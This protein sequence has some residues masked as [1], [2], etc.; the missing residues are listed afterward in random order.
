MKQLTIDLYSY[1]ELNKSAKEKA[2][3]SLADFLEERVVEDITEEIKYKLSEKGY[4]TEN[5]RWDID[6]NYILFEGKIE[7]SS[8]LRET[9]NTDMPSER[10]QE[11]LNLGKFNIYVTTF[12]CGNI[13]KRILDVGVEATGNEQTDLDILYIKYRILNSLERDVKE[14]LNIAKD[15]YYSY[16][17][18][19]VIQDITEGEDIMFLKDGTM[20]KL[21]EVL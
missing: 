16:F 14:L 2:Y 12:R 3:D 21:N 6:K 18:D 15:T 9:I 20:I 19:D 13:S 1:K 7:Y 17:E 11:L 10:V 5:I 4:P 8:Q